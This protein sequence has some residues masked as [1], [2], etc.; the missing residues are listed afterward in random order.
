MLVLRLIVGLILLCLAGINHFLIYSSACDPSVLISY[1]TPKKE[2]A[3]IVAIQVALVFQF[4]LGVF[5]ILGMVSPYT[6]RML[7]FFPL[8]IVLLVTN[9]ELLVTMLRNHVSEYCKIITPRADT[10]YTICSLLAVILFFDRISIRPCIAVVTLIAILTILTAIFGVV[11]LK[12]LKIVHE[13]PDPLRVRLPVKIFVFSSIVFGFQGMAV[14]FAPI[15]GCW[16]ALIGVLSLM[17]SWAVTVYRLWKL[18]VLK[19]Y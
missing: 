1:L 2:A 4:V 13:L 5:N 18:A 15:V 6:L 17:V 16:L 14:Y 10:F 9:A 7:T 8:E 19:Y 12:Y 11:L 3:H